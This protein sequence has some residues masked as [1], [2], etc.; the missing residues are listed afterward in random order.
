MFH[1]KE[2]EQNREE[3]K[4]KVKTNE[5]IEKIDE[6]ETEWKNEKRRIREKTNRR[7]KH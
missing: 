3:N 5:S 1:F 4:T 2:K 7:P 6:V